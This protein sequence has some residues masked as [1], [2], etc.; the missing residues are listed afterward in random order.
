MH[1][2]PDRLDLL[3]PAAGPVADLAGVPVSVR[4]PDGHQVSAPAVALVDGLGEIFGQQARDPL[5]LDGADLVHRQW[6]RDTDARD[7]RGPRAFYDVEADGDWPPF[8]YRASPAAGSQ[9]HEQERGWP[10]PQ[11]DGDPRKALK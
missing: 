7:R 2:E 10:A 3:W 8:R 11:H 9:R 6:L 5:P 1:Q 4:D